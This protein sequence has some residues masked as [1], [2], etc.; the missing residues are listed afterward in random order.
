MEYFLTEIL[1]LKELHCREEYIC[2]DKDVTCR[3]K[4]EQWKAME[5]KHEKVLIIVLLKKHFVLNLYLQLLLLKHI[6]VFRYYWVGYP[7]RSVMK[8]TIQNK[9]TNQ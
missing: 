1:C 9:Q 8:Q 5:E 4:N 6:I 2:N 3:L 7:A